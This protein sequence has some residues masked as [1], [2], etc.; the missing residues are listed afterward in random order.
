MSRVFFK[1]WG[2][3][4]AKWKLPPKTLEITRKNPA[5]FRKTSAKTR[6]SQNDGANIFRFSG[7]GDAPTWQCCAVKWHETP[8]TPDFFQDNLQVVSFSNLITL[9][10]TCALPRS[11]QVYYNYVLLLVQQSCTI[12]LEPSVDHALGFYPQFASDEKWCKCLSKPNIASISS[13]PNLTTLRKA[14]E[15]LRGF[16][17][18]RTGARDEA[19]GDPACLAGDSD[20]RPLGS[21]V[22][23]WAFCARAWSASAKTIGTSIWRWG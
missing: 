5:T 16:E 11:F 19:G 9:H 23:P 15:F 4:W 2:L 3:S 14:P 22:P 20:H 1:V 17:G 10:C 8:E 6:K 13:R 21:V 12:F 7:F 18:R